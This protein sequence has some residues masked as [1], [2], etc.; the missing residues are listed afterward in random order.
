MLCSIIPQGR[1]LFMLYFLPTSQGGR[2]ADTIVSW[3]R[4]RTGPAAKKLAAG[5]VEAFSSSNKVVI[6]GFFDAE[7]DADFQAFESFAKG[8]DEFT[9]GVVFD[10]EAAKGESL[11]VLLS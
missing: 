6:V 9:F 1:F 8:N 3:L 5:E 4:K 2:T 7:A 11:P 10:A